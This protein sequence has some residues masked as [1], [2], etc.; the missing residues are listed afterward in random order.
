MPG[1]ELQ[2]AIFLD[3]DGVINAPPT[4]GLYITSPEELQII[5]GVPEAIVRFREAGYLVIVVTNQSGIARGV[6]THAQVEA[7]HDRMRQVLA[8]EGAILDDIF[9]CPHDDADGCRC[10]KPKPGMLIEAAVRHDIDLSRSVMVGDQERDI[11]A[12]IAAGCR[13]AFVAGNSTCEREV[14]FINSLNDASIDEIK[15]LFAGGASLN[16]GAPPTLP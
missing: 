15:R 3:R 4:S 7:V 9:Y 16:A 6:M 1:S 5:D 14:W 2:R 8:A 13:T 10:R 11:E 12:G